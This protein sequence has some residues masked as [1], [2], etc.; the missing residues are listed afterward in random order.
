MLLAERR[1]NNT[2]FRLERL[3][4]AKTAR[5]HLSEDSVP[6]A[7]GRVASSLSDSGLTGGSSSLRLRPSEEGV[8]EGG[9]GERGGGAGQ[10]RT[11]VKV[12]RGPDWK[13]SDQDGGEGS[14]GVVVSGSDRNADGWVRVQWSNGETNGYRWGV[15]KAFDLEMLEASPYAAAL[16]LGSCRFLCAVPGASCAPQGVLCVAGCR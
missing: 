9:G 13:W 10:L 1:R 11:G 12:K 7:L 3:R 5:H 8:T 15:E 2:E 14:T 4:R 6:R 16:R